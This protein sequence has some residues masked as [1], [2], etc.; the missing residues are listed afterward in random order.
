ML[1][2]FGFCNF[3]GFAELKYNHQIFNGIVDL[4]ETIGPLFYRPNH[5]H[6]R[7]GLFR[8]VPER[9]ILGL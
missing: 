3:A 9:W 2:E 7:F 1:I 6:V 8:I 4:F 5:F